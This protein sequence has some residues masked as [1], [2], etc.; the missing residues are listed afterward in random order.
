MV[1]RLRLFAFVG[2]L[3][4]FAVACG[5]K[6]GVHQGRVVSG[7][8]L[9]DGTVDDLEDFEEFEGQELGEGEEIVTD[10][11]GRQVV[12]RRQTSGGGG[13]NGGS[14]GGSGGQAAEG[15]RTGVS[16]E[17]IRIGIHAPVSGA[18]PFPARAF[19]LGRDVYWK[20]SGAPTIHGRQVRVFFEDDHYDPRTARDVCRKMVEEDNA[21]LL[22]GGGGTDQIQEC[23]RWSASQGVPYLSAGVTEIGMDNLRN[24]FALSM[25]Y[26]QQGPLLWQLIQSDER[27]APHVDNVAMVYTNTPNFG[28]ARQAFVSAMEASGKQLVLE[29]RMSKNP[30]Q[31]EYSQTALALQNAGAEVVYILVAPTHYVQLTARLS[32]GYEPWWVGVGITKALNDVLETGCSTSRGAIDNGLFFSPF[33]GLDRIDQMDGDYR[34]AYREVNPGEEPDDLGMAFW[35]LSKT[36]HR[37]FENAG[38]DLHRQGFIQT[39][40]QSEFQSGVFPNIQYSPQNHFGADSVHLLKADCDSEQH[41][42]VKTFARSF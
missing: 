36:L 31:T 16:D 41:Q 6:P 2:I 37:M 10:E 4:L 24:Y 23:A 38:R 25:S 18:A 26:P 19:A 7:E 9:E 40:E 12:R 22:I 29:R 27:L 34:R 42:T 13:A 5:Q 3:A 35:G 15:D 32:Q 8:V 1:Q 33:P 14:G 30:S 28:D 20:W 39:T 11:Q 21:F 17:E